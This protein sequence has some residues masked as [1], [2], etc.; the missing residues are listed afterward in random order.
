MWFVGGRQWRLVD[1]YQGTKAEEAFWEVLNNGG[2]IGGS[3]AG[4]TIQGSYLVRGDTKNNQVMMGDHEEG[5]WIYQKYSN[6]STC[7]NKK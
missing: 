1:S 7:F 6:R 3:S 5:F 4:A 2:V